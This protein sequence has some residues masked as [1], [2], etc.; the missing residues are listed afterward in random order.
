M[1]HT[2]TEP[3]LH[4]GSPPK[5]PSHTKVRDS[6]LELW[7]CYFFNMTAFLWCCLQFFWRC[8]QFF[9]RCLQFFLCWLQKKS[10]DCKK[11]PVDCKKAVM[12]CPSHT[13]A[14]N[15][16]EQEAN[17]PILR[18][19]SFPHGDYGTGNCLTGES[20]GQLTCKESSRRSAE[21]ETLQRMKNR[22]G[23]KLCNVNWSP[24]L[25]RHFHLNH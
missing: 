16:Q 22:D 8:L 18:D 25:W 11:K 13:K 14:G 3:G 19:F 2:C 7:K 20:H 12:K 5:G 6:S 24:T 17:F 9:R 21:R 1:L 23:S 15:E 4:S 10:V